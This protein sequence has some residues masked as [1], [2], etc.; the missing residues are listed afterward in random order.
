MKMNIEMN[1]MKDMEDS[2]SVY[3]GEEDREVYDDI[4]YEDNNIS[5]DF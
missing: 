5:D 2:P 4:I 1:M 3:D